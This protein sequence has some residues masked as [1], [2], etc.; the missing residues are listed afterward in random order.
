MSPTP[1]NQESILIR[2]PM[3][4]HLNGWMV[5]K[6]RPVYHIMSGITGC[7]YLKIP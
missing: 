1:L 4:D 3:K 2:F 7:F 5:E 6:K